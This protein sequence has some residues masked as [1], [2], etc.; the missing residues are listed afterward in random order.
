MYLKITKA[1]VRNH[2]GVFFLD[3]IGC[4]DIYHV[5]VSK[6]ALWELIEQLGSFKRE[7][8]YVDSDSFNDVPSGKSG[9]P[10]IVVRIMAEDEADEANAMIKRMER[11]YG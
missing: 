8:L 2:P 9:T 5:R 7:H 3:A 10:H 6:V 4:E 11:A 1:M